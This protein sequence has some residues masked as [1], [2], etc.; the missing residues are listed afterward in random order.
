MAGP[1]S[2]VTERN[3]TGWSDYKFLTGQIIP[4]ITLQAYSFLSKGQ[5]LP[6]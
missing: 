5:S 6:K 2:S 4:V 3:H 1:A